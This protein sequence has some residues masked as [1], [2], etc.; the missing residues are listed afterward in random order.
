MEILMVRE[1]TF[2]QLKREASEKITIPAS[3]DAGIVVKRGWVYDAV[4]INPKKKKL[5]LNKISKTIK[6]IT[7]LFGYHI[8]RRKIRRKLWK[9][10]VYYK[11]KKVGDC[12]VSL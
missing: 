1:E 10:L 7:E 6:M 5:N 2:E 8:S 3:D 9:L 12:G 4:L 11:F